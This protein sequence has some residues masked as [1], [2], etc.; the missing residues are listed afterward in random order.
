MHC[1]TRHEVGSRLAGYELTGAR[2]E[3]TS[4]RAGIVNGLLRG[5]LR[6]LL[7]DQV[8]ILRESLQL[9]LRLQVLLRLL[10]HRGIDLIRIRLRL[11]PCPNG[12]AD[13][14]CYAVE[15]AYP[16]RVLKR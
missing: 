4:V 8:V 14:V 16:S 13:P 5:Q 11:L 9:L 2:Y 12:L 15:S 3:L 7:C 1:D 10:E 6:E